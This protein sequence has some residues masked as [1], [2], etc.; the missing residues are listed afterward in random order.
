MRWNISLSSIFANAWS[1]YSFTAAKLLKKYELCVFILNY[2]VPLQTQMKKYVSILVVVA[3]L[4][5]CSHGRQKELEQFRLKV[6]S[7]LLEE[8]LAEA[9]QKLARTDSILQQRDGDA[10]STPGYMDSLEIAADVQGAQIRY[11]HRKQ[12]EIQ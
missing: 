12:K 11:I 7:Q 8:K 6:R 4:A 9:Q 10:D 2:F 5:S 3:V 1:E